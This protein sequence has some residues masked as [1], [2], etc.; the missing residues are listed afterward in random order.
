MKVKLGDTL[1]AKSTV[2]CTLAQS[3]NHEPLRKWDKGDVGRICGVMMGIDGELSVHIDFGDCL[4]E[5]AI[6]DL[7]TY[8][9]AAH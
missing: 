7:G 4:E 9:Q 5:L 1:I 8:F 6:S 2:L 3:H